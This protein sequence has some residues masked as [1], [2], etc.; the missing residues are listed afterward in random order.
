MKLIIQIPCKNEA[1]TLPQT[2]ADLPR[3]VPGFDTVELLVIDDGSTDGTSEVAQA[4][5]VHH[6]LRFPINRGL[7]YAFAAG[8][9]ASLERGADVVVNTDGDNQYQGRYVLALVKPIV[10]G[11][12]DLV[13]GDRRVA[14]VP[15]FSSL[16]RLLQYVGSWVVRW[17]SGTDVPDATSGFRALSREAAL[18]LSVFSAYTYTLETII[19]AGKRGLIVRSVPVETN[20]PTRRSRL[21]TSIPGYVLRSGVTILRVVLMYDAL[22]AFMTLGTF[23][24][25]A[26][27]VLVARFAYYWVTAQGAGHIQS[28]IAAAILIII[29]FLT[30]LLGLL[31]DLIARNR[32]LLEEQVYLL[33]KLSLDRGAH[34]P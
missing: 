13:I 18:R 8:L 19:Q 27:G 11:E 3:E 5:G 30:F 14:Q 16:K 31:A 12:A 6:I 1:Q 7:A 29:G 24:L 32:Q 22:R 26:G 20:P 2:V 10:R 4:L 34:S 9:Q 17:A 23:P 25:A 15:Y 21:I 28:L 33:R